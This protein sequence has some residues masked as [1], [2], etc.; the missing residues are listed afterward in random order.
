MG[1][2]TGPELGAGPSVWMHATGAICRRLSEWSQ[3]DWFLTCGDGQVHNRRRPKARS[4]RRSADAV[5]SGRNVGPWYHPFDRRYMPPEPT[6]VRSKWEHRRL[7]DVC[8]TAAVPVVE[9]FSAAAVPVPASPGPAQTRSPSI[10]LQ[11]SMENHVDHREK[12][13]KDELDRLFET[14]LAFVSQVRSRVAPRVSQ[15]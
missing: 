8:L 14:A 10:A 11:P 2:C 15:P 13:W 6:S 3:R 7:R 9:L 1:R 4:S 12:L 5:L